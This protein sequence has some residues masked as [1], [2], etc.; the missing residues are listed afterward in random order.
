[1]LHSLKV[2][3][4]ELRIIKFIDFT[5]RLHSEDP[6]VL[7]M[8]RTMIKFTLWRLRLTQF[9]SVFMKGLELHEPKPILWSLCSA[10]SA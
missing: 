8:L 3:D 2:H 4:C 1:M 5:A 6:E 9:N 7:H 10:L